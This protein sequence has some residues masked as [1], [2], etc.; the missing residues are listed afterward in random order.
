MIVPHL[1]SLIVLECKKNSEAVLTDPEFELS[2]LFVPCYTHPE[3]LEVLVC[4]SVPLRHVSFL[5]RC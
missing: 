5:K 1:R 4:L 2:G 3:Q